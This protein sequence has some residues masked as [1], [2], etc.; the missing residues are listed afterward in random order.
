MDCKSH[1]KGNSMHRCMVLGIQYMCYCKHFCY[2]IEPLYTSGTCAKWKLSLKE[3]RTSIEAVFSQRLVCSLRNERNCEIGHTVKCSSSCSSECHQKAWSPISAM[4][5]VFIS[6]VCLD[7]TAGY[8]YVESCSTHPGLF[9]L[10]STQVA[11]PNQLLESK[12]QAC[13]PL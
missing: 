3:S 1:A 4:V 12:S 6:S 11:N 7:S 9:F 2:S 13:V 5:E 10:F 8:Q